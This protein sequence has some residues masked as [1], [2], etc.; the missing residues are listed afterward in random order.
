MRVRGFPTRFGQRREVIFFPSGSNRPV[1]IRALLK[2]GSNVGVAAP[3]VSA[4]GEAELLRARDVDVFV[5]SGAFG[6]VTPGP[7]GV[8]VT[9]PFTHEKWIKVLDLYTRLARQLG[10]RL[11]AVAPDQVGS[12]EVTLERMARYGAE[13][14][15]LTALGARVILPIQQGPI[16][17]WDLWVQLLEASGLDPSLAVAGV[18]CCKCPTPAGEVA[19]FSEQMNYDHWEPG[20]IHIL[21]RGPASPIWEDYAA[22]CWHHHV[23]ADACR[24]LAMKGFTSSG[25]PRRLQ[26]AHQLAKETLPEPRAYETAVEQVFRSEIQ[27]L[28]L[29]RPVGQMALF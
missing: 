17:M 15:E 1:E 8:V 29:S 23:S 11:Y 13:L 20:R 24:W 19:E 4:N 26:V 18:P 28:K 7:T 9:K 14:R 21:G 22:A 5:D 16:G 10:G 12:Q 3:R 27:R 2:A 25:K 6:E